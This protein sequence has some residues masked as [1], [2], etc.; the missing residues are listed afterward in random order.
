MGWSYNHPKV[1]W[2]YNFA[3][4]VTHPYGGQGDAAEASVPPYIGLFMGLFVCPH[5]WYWFS[6]DLGIQEK[7]S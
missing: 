7:A 5:E 1:D 2:G 4:K 3:P 6:P